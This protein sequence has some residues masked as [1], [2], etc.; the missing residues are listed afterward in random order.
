MNDLSFDLLSFFPLATPQDVAENRAWIE[1]LHYN[2]ATGK[3]ALSMHS[4]LVEANGKKILIDG[5]VGN[6]KDRPGRPQWHQLDTSFLSRMRQLGAHPE[7]IDYVMCTHLHADHVGW[8]TMLRNGRWV[9]TFP[10][11]RYVFSRREQDFWARE[12]AAAK[13]GRTNY[14]AMS[15]EDSVLPVIKAEQAIIVDDGFAVEDRLLIEEAPGHTPGHVAIWL[16]AGAAR[17]V[18]TGDIIHHPIQ[19]RYPHWSCMGCMDPEMANRSRLRI[20]EACADTNAM[21]LPA[22]FLAPHAGRVR[23]RGQSFDLEFVQCGEDHAKEACAPTP[24]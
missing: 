17:G 24:P 15:Y 7:E 6:H 2:H 1:P 9:P 21:L 16:S 23:R 13:T 3:I 8:N 22:H 5:C 18:F 4:W 10:K 19:M 12:L 14:H 11:A 20:L